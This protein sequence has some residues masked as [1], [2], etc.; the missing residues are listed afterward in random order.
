MEIRLIT[1]A[2]AYEAAKNTIS[3]IDTKNFE[4]QNLVVVPDAFSMQA[5]SLIFDTLKIKSTFNIE[6]VGISRLAGKILNDN[7]IAFKRISAL[8]EVFCIYKAVS[9]CKDEFKY[10]KNVSVDLCMKILQIIKQF[11]GCKIKPEQIK[12]VGDENLDNKMSDLRMI[13]QKYETLLSD[14][15]DLSK[16]LQFF[17]ENAKK[18]I[19]LSKIN[20]FFANFDS[21]SAEIGS[22]ICQLAP[23]VNAVYVGMAKPIS[24][25]NA[26]IFEDD[27]LKKMTQFSKENNVSIKVDMLPTQISGPNLDVVKNVFGFGIDEGKSDFFVN[28]VAKN[29]RDEV[30][31]VAK[32]IKFQIASGKKFN[33]FAIAVPDK[34]YVDLIK[35]IFADYDIVYYSDDA[36]NLSQT[37]LGK[38]LFKMIEIAKVGFD[39]QAFEFFA[40]NELANPSEDVLKEI[41]HFCVD[42]AEEF[43]QRFPELS[44]CVQLVRNISCSVTLSDFVFAMKSVLEF[45]SEKHQELLENLQKKG[46]FKEESENSQAQELI[47]KVLDKLVEVGGQEKFSIFDFENLLKFSFESVKVETIPSYLDAVYVGDATESYFEDKNTLFVLGATSN[48]LPKT[49]SDLGLIDDLEIKKLRLAFA[50]EPEIRVLNRR[51]RLKLFELL[52]HAKE[53]LIVTTPLADDG[54]QTE[55]SGFVEDLL[56]LFGQ[57]VVHTA[58][59]EEFGLAKFSEDEEFDRILFSIGHPGNLSQFY[60]KSKDKLPKKWV[61]TIKSLIKTTFPTEK[62]LEK[63]ENFENVKKITKISASQLETFFACPFRYF[64]NYV[65]RISPREDV[66]PTRAQFGTLQHAVVQ[67]FFTDFDDVRKVDEKQID[68]FLKNNLLA[69]AKKVYDEKVLQPVFVKFLRNESKIIIKNAINEQKFSDFRPVFAEKKI[70]LPFDDAFLDGRVDRVDT[71]GDFFRVIDYKTGHTG[72]LKTELFYGKKLQLFLYAAAIEKELN[73]KCAGVYYFNCQT[74]YSKQG[75]AGH[76]LKGLTIKDENIVVATDHRLS[77]GDFKS[78][79]IAAETRANPKKDEFAFKGSGLDF[80]DD[81]IAYALEISKRA[82]KEIK[83]GYFVP[84]P[85]AKECENCPYI[86]VC[87]HADADGFRKILKKPAKTKTDK[88]P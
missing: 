66:Q 55:K 1:G 45:V 50:L 72:T 5:E 16:L 8:E 64:V 30:E 70:G 69:E 56:K 59:L 74:K 47:L 28:V 9:L 87:R 84:K 41:R 35:D 86:S 49:R 85:F 36:V 81:K 12:N 33:D 7:N 52:Q 23:L 63:I 26:F 53:K 83:E 80:V 65:L 82:L 6:V 25:K 57:N 18:S 79:I 71:F 60:T 54:Q 17:V 31:F 21:F 78:N 22:F 4:F 15:M 43:M 51:S 40:S 44:N 3:Q 27:I 77:L 88:D 62:R 68:K 39:R 14:K 75:D 11:Q 10:F 19:N 73:K 76:L 29:V 42:D 13:Y 61:G 38:F 20:L 67:K 34:K 2:T 24:V 37:V 32:Y 46:F 48:L 58:A